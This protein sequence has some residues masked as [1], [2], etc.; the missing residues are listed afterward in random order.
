MITI[1]DIINKFNNLTKNQKKI[2]VLTVILIILLIGTGILKNISNL[3]SKEWSYKDLTSAGDILY[4]GQSVKNDRI[5][6]WELKD[7]IDNY[8][9]TMEDAEFDSE[10]STTYVL[11]D[12]YEVISKEYRK[13]LNK[14]EFENNST[15]LISKFLQEDHLG[16]KYVDMFYIK[17]IYLFD[18][19]KYL[20]ALA[21]S[22]SS[23]VLGYIGIE[24]NQKDATFSIFY[25]E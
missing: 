14:E 5:L 12:Y 3:E 11:S 22:E 20:C 16:N 24:M 6:Y 2:I 21:L 18:K 15:E 25:I 8:F 1:F 17:D 4:R 10:K 19:T 9:S 13:R 23:D 7:I